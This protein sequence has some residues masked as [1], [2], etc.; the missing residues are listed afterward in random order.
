MLFILHTAYKEIS[1]IPN[2]KYNMN[3]VTE[4]LVNEIITEMYKKMY[5]RK[6]FI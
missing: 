1:N 2:C 5:S 4:M 3:I 6:F